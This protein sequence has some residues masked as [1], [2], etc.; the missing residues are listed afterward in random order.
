MVTQAEPIGFESG[1]NDTKTEGA[2]V[3]AA[4]GQTL[5][6]TGSP[7]SGLSGLPRVLGWFWVWSL[8]LLRGSQ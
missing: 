2:E 3:W 6:V 5:L 8:S 1:P 4:L 7:E